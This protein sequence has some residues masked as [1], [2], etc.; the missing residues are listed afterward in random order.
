MF[1]VLV[2]YVL[3]VSTCSKVHTS[4]CLYKSNFRCILV[5]PYVFKTGPKVIQQQSCGWELLSIAV[6]VTLKNYVTDSFFR[7]LKYQFQNCSLKSLSSVFLL[8][9][10]KRCACVPMLCRN[11]GPLHWCKQ[12]RS[13][14]V[15][16]RNFMLEN[17]RILPKDVYFQ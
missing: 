9:L 6:V 3:V 13:V 12:I 4:L 14:S 1:G 8:F 5:Y 17:K 2:A 7:I 11:M 10:G 15:L 16:N